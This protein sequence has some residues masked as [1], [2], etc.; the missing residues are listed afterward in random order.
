[1]NVLERVQPDV[2]RHRTHKDVRIRSQVVS[3]TDTPP[4]QFENA[5][6]AI[7]RE[8]FVAAHMHAAEHL[9]GFS[10]ADSNGKG[11]SERDDEAHLTARQQRCR[12]QAGLCVHI[13]KVRESIGPDHV[14]SNILQYQADSGRPREADRGYL[15]QSLPAPE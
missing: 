11:G 3:H 13:A 2:G 1:M 14:F 9:D 10:L 7:M 6:D 15:K 4:L 8:Q 12:G 5:V